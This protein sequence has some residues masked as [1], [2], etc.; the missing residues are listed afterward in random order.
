MVLLEP[1]RAL[2]VSWVCLT[3]SPINRGLN[4]W[5]GI[6]LMVIKHTALG[7]C[8][9]KLVGFFSTFCNK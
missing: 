1:K 5:W 7:S 9:I 6:K 4:D 8:A 2:K 3:K